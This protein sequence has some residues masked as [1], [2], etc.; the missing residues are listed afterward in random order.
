MERFNTYTISRPRLRKY[1]GWSLVVFG[2]LMLITPLTP[3]GLLFFVGLEILGFRIV[4]TDRIKKFLK[5]K[6]R[7]AKIAFE[8]VEVPVHEK[9]S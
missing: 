1:V 3:G 2:F 6:T 8:T 9:T 4:G 7:S 5:R